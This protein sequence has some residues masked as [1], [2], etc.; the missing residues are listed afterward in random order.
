MAHALSTAASFATYESA[1]AAH[2][3]SVTANGGQHETSVAAAKEASHQRV[4]CM[5]ELKIP[6]GPA[7]RPFDY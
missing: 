2:T 1:K 5:K 7:D 3:A 4:V 6:I